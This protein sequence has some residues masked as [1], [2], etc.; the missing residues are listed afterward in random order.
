MTREQITKMNDSELE[1]LISD[2][3]TKTEKEIIEFFI[4]IVDECYLYETS[5]DVSENLK[6]SENAI[7]IIKS[8]KLEKYKKIVLESSY[9][10]VDKINAEISK[11]QNK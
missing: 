5:N 2:V 1:N 9:N 8:K 11:L 10:D 4:F 7:K 3:L 6:N